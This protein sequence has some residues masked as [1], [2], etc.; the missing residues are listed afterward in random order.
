LWMHIL[1]IKGKTL[2]ILFQERNFECLQNLVWWGGGPVENKASEFLA[3]FQ[4]RI[5][6]VNST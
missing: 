6:L 1:V 5:F 3:C 4:P 2:Y